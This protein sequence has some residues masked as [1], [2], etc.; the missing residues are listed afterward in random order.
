MKSISTVIAI[1]ILF[2]TSCSNEKK[3]SKATF[4]KSLN[5]YFSK[6]P[7]VL[8]SSSIDFP[9]VM[10]PEKKYGSN[11]KSVEAL[12]GVKLVEFKGDTTIREGVTKKYDVSN[13]GKKFFIEFSM[14]GLLGKYNYQGFVFAKETV[15]E[16][17]SY[18]E[19]ADLMGKKVSEVKFKSKITNVENWAKDA[20][21]QEN[22]ESIKKYLSPDYAEQIKSAVFIL[23]SDGW[24]HEQLYSEN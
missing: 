11:K 17:V 3:A 16:I 20:S 13:F 15:A 4:T 2:I 14:M 21:I 1:A 19:P 23:T 5:T 7:P 8:T 12:V 24:V 6:R 22:F 18:T 10:Q 9:G